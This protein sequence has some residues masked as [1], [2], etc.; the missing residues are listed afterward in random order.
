MPVSCRFS[1]PLVTEKR[2][3]EQWRGSQ[4]AFDASVLN[5]KTDSSACLQLAC[6]RQPVDDAELV[7][8]ANLLEMLLGLCRLALAVPHRRVEAVLFEK[9]GTRA[10][11]GDLAALQHDDLVR[12][13]DGGETVGDD[14][15]RAV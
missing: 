2:P 3:D 10:A 12:A 8:L 1:Y 6:R 5:N 14:Q 7:A 13:N 11:F 9:G 15:R 4:A